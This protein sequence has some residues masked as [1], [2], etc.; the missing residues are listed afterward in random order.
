MDE[1]PDTRYQRKVSD[2]SY[3]ARQKS[4][5]L[6]DY[7][8]G[9]PNPYSRTVVVRVDL[10]YLDIVDPLLRIGHRDWHKAMEV[11][12]FWKKITRGAWLLL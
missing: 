4:A 5:D 12:E 2:R 8:R 3:Q 6:A 7:V 9:V 10:H 11:G 1:I